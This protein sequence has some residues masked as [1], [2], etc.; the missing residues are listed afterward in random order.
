MKAVVVREFAPFEQI[1]VSELPD[2]KPGRG[3]VVIAR[4]FSGGLWVLE[5]WTREAGSW[6]VLTSQVT[7]AKP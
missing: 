3:E 5:V 1:G 2:P 4:F 6:K 7:T